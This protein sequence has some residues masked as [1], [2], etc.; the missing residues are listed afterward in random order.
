[1]GLVR[2]QAFANSGVDSYVVHPLGNI[3]CLCSGVTASFIMAIRF[4]PLYLMK[5]RQIVVE[6]SE[7]KLLAVII[8]YGG[9]H[10]QKLSPLR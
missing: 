1:M 2:C 4:M 3:P 10:L 8:H 9:V 5:L 6:Y 7:A